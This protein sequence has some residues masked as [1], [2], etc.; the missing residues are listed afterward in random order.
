MYPGL[1]SR[2]QHDLRGRYLRDILRGDVK[3]LAKFKL[4]IEDPPRRKHMVFLGAS[5]LG[6]I[7]SSKD[8]YWLKKSDYREMGERRGAARRSAA[9]VCGARGPQPQ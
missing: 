3:R 8:D 5:V 9:P 7:M 1:P 2:L 4:H 6:D